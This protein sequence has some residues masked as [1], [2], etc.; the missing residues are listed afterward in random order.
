MKAV[1]GFT[2]EDYKKECIADGGEVFEF[3]SIGEAAE[4][5]ASWMRCT[6]KVAEDGIRNGTNCDW[7]VF[8][9]GSVFFRY[10]GRNYGEE[11][12]KAL[13]DRA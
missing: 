10:Y 13:R 12:I 11:Y 1:K 7:I 9:D 6:E 4:S 2:K 5:L 3:A 8:E